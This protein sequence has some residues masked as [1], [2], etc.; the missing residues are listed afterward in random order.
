MKDVRDVSLH[1]VKVARLPCRQTGVSN[2]DLDFGDGR[3]KKAVAA[4]SPR[5]GRRHM[6]NVVMRGMFLR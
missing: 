3:R 6:S 1:R 4:R 5:E 2:G